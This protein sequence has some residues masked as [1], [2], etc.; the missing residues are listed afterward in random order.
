MSKQETVEVTVKLPKAIVDCIRD[1]EGDPAKWISK[2]I[3]DLLV[4]YIECVDE[5]QLMDKYDL[6]P[7][8]REHGV[9]PCYYNL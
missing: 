5:T 7:V 3:I 8:F 2:Q 4:S 6:K 1:M 9:L